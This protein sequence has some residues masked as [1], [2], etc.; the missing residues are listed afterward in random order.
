MTEWEP[1][2]NAMGGNDI[3][4]LLDTR[5]WY[6]SGHTLSVKKGA[7]QVMETYKKLSIVHKDEDLPNITQKSNLQKSKTSFSKF[8][9]SPFI[10][11]YNLE[12]SRPTIWDPA[13][14]VM[15]KLEETRTL[16]L[17]DVSVTETT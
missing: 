4:T 14:T 16:M 9:Q 7:P 5:F 2:D 12:T 13:K 6:F 17:G 15:P 11:F 8:I 3:Y 10:T 1:S